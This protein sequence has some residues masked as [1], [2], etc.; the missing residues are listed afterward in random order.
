MPL[1]VE[2]FRTR[3][4]IRVRLTNVSTKHLAITKRPHSWSSVY[5]RADG[6][7]LAEGGAAI[8]AIP[9]EFLDLK[10]SW[11]RVERPYQPS[12]LNSSI[13]KGGSGLGPPTC[14]PMAG[15]MGGACQREGKALSYSLLIFTSCRKASHGAA[16]P[17]RPS[18]FLLPPSRTYAAVPRQ[19]PLQ[20]AKFHGAANAMVS[21]FVEAS[22]R[23]IFRAGSR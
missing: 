15:R 5:E 17:P 4:E 18:F 22:W 19:M 12:R 2:V 7:K 20:L 1:Q 16:R 6:S 9:T 23:G 13:S 14:P 10:G 11:Q 3:D 21:R 8:P